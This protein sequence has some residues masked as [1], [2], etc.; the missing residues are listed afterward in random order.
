MNSD[1]LKLK[2]KRLIRKIIIGVLFMFGFC[3]LMVPLYSLVCKQAGINGRGNFRATDDPTIK[4]DKSRTIQV[5]FSTMIHGNL[6]MQFRPLI[7]RINIHP[8]ETKEVYFFAENDTG[9]R[10]TVQ[11]VPSIAPGE[12]AKYLKK[13]ECFCFTQQSFF[14]GEKADMPV[15]FRIDPDVPKE[16]KFVVLNYTMF[17]AMQFLKKNQKQLTKNRIELPS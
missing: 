17:D 8:G 7:R 14:K 11:A 13:T 10:I 12:A 4:I 3:Y 5:E 6:A 16:V 9:K 1:D 2:N 15:I